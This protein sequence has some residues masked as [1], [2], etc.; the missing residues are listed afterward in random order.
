MA[1]DDKNPSQGKHSIKKDAD[2]TSSSLITGADAYSREAGHY[3]HRKGTNS[4]MGKGPRRAIAAVIALVVV[5]L[6]GFGV[7]YSSANNSIRLIDSKLDESLSKTASQEPFWTL[8]LGSDS[9]STSTEG[10]RSDVIM[11]C[12]VDPKSKQVTMVSIPRDTKVHI[13]GYGTQK[14]N[15]AYALGGAS[16]AVDVIGSYANVDI[17]H[18]VE[19]YFGGVEDL[20]DALGGVTV[21]VPE[22]CSYQDVTLQPGE[23][24]L[25]GH[26]ALI[27][28]RC[29][30]TYAMGDFRRTECQRILLQALVKK[31]LAM[32]AAEIPQFLNSVSECFAVDSGWSIASLADLALEMKDMDADAMYS[33]MAP[34]DTGMENGAS[35]TYTYVYQWMLLME[36]A[37]AGEDPSLD[38]EEKNICGY[39][40]TRMIDM[41]WEAG[42]PQEV[43][44]QLDAY[45]AE[46]EAKAAEEANKAEDAQANGGEGSASAAK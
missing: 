28:A 44:D 45:Q 14:I 38:D 22:Y 39:A 26:Q 5:F 37:C 24:T 30:K 25:N 29:R 18:Y 8:I 32:D 40:D 20:V 15:A 6:I 19:V 21:N 4:R 27:F 7:W 23:Q 33:A 42:I 13:E 41:D 9:R 46:K 16:L 3:E 10:T 31:V 2:S 36:R 34:S 35:Y 1:A 43:R 12:R 17:S 11:L